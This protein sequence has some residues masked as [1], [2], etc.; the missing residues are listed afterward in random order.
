MHDFHSLSIT[1]GLDITGYYQF[2]AI[3][4]PICRFLQ[5]LGVDFQFDTKITDTVI[6]PSDGRQTVSRLDVI[7]NGYASQKHL[8]PHDI[9]IIT[10]GSTVSESAIGTNSLAPVRLP[11][12][13]KEEPDQNWSLW[14]GLSSKSDKFGNPYN[15]SSCQSE[16]ILESFTITTQDTAFFRYLN[17]LARSSPKDGVFISLR[18]SPWRLNVCVPIQPVFPQQ[19]EDVHV[20]WGFALFPQCKGKYMKRAMTKCSGEEIM[21]ELLR[22]LNLPPDLHIRRTV[23]IPRVMPRMSSFLL[24]RSLRDRPNI[25]PQD[26]TNIGLVGQFVDIPHHSCVDMS[27]SVRTAQVAV[28]QLM[29][30]DLL[31][32]E[33]KKFSSPVIL[34]FMFWK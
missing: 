6:F 18:E 5:S 26:T 34:K 4:L 22:H 9:V 17:S 30:V 13:A 15:F 1:R 31:Q 2:E 19:P 7:Q 3:F 20:L 27:Y 11:I 12:G 10:L 33:R 23:T 29:G 16:S 28:S 8:R 32:V 14:F 21:V 24:S 25:I